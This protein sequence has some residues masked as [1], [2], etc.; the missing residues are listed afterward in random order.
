M[1]G[2]GKVLTK[3]YMRR[4]EIRSLLRLRDLDKEHP[5]YFKR[6]VYKCPAFFLIQRES[7]DGSIKTG[8]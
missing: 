8:S 5:L 1:H 4:G 6:E 2:D 7:L 3:T